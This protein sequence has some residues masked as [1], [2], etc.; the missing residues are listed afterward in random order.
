VLN[1]N[2]LSLTVRSTERIRSYYYIATLSLL[3]HKIR[4]NSISFFG[5]SFTPVQFG[6]FYPRSPYVHRVWNFV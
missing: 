4:H 2:V 3:F 6:H 5:V 1:I